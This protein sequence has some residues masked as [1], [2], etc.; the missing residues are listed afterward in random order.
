MLNFDISR[1]S[2]ESGSER[3]EIHPKPLFS[4]PSESSGSECASS[5]RNLSPAGSS[6]AHFSDTDIRTED[7]KDVVRILHALRELLATELDYV[8]DLRVLSVGLVQ[9]GFQLF[10]L[11]IFRNKVYIQRLS[12][13][14]VRASAFARAS[15]TFTSGPWVN[16]YAGQTLT[17]VDPMIPSAPSPLTKPVF[18]EVEIDVLSRNINDILQMHDEFLSTLQELL[19]PLGCSNATGPHQYESEDVSTL[20]SVLKNVSRAFIAEVGLILLCSYAHSFMIVGYIGI[21]I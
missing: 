20:I 4:S 15:A 13:F 17:L 12:R 21:Q 8:R 7:L 10:Q 1:L 5:L 16:A 6:D 11:L 3:V 19:L 18:T 2:G 9:D 14:E